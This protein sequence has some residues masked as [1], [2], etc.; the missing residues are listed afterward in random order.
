MGLRLSP[1]IPKAEP[2]EKTIATIIVRRSAT[3]LSRTIAMNR[4]LHGALAALLL[5]LMI[6][7]SIDPARVAADGKD[8]KKKSETATE[9]VDE[10]DAIGAWPQYKIGQ[11]ERILVWYQNDQWHVLTTTPANHKVVFTGIIHFHDGKLQADRKR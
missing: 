1:C 5:G 9:T 10:P 7:W 4:L 3:I 2:N 8:K 6:L 11:K